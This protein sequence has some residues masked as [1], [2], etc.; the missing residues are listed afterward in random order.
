[1]YAHTNMLYIS[2]LI[3]MSK[4]KQTTVFPRIVRALRIDRALE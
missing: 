3:Q 2:S 1:M 4:V